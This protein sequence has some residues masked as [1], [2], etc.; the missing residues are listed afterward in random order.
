VGAGVDQPRPGG[1]RAS[2]CGTYSPCPGGCA[3][4]RAAPLERRHGHLLT[5]PICGQRPAQDRDRGGAG[6]PVP[7]QQ[8]QPAAGRAGPGAG[9][10]TPVATYLER[11]LWQ[12]LGME[13]DGSWSLDSRRSGSE[14]MESGPNGRAIDF[15]KLGLLYANGRWR[16]R[17]LV[18]APGSRTRPWSPPGSA[19]RPLPPTG[20]SGGP[21]RPAAAAVRRGQVRPAHLR[22]AEHQAG[23]GPVRPRRGSPVLAAASQRSGQAAGRVDLRQSV[24][25]LDS[26]LHERLRPLARV[27]HRFSSTRGRQSA[28]LPSVLAGEPCIRGHSA[29]GTGRRGAPTAWR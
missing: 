23:P 20:S 28:D 22:G 4:T 12:P 6:T 19:K 11:T 8:L 9:P 15:A 7:R 29:T 2:P 10:G 21:G 18:R 16:G 17:Q 14:K 27:S 24:M 3:M 5:R 13:A 1:S 26:G 25:T